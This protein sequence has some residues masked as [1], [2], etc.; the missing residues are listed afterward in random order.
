MLGRRSHTMLD[1]HLLD[2]REHDSFGSD[3]ED[4]ASRPQPKNNRVKAVIFMNLFAILFSCYQLMMK[5]NLNDPN[6]ID[7]LDFVLARTG[8]CMVGSAVITL[9]TGSTFRV[10]RSQWRPL[11]LRNFFGAF[12]FILYTFGV[13]YCP[14]VISSILFNTTPFWTAI[15]AWCFF[16]DSINKFTCFA[17]VVSFI[18]VGLIC[19]SHPKREGAVEHTLKQQVMGYI[20]LIAAA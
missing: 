20:C 2:L 19:S 12:C 1:E 15:L 11:F 10:E 5:K 18:G 14:L 3:E 13:E 7:N 8:A 4:P 6:N 17:L 9:C 16:N